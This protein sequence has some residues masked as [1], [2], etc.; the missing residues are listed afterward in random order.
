[1]AGRSASK[2]ASFSCMRRR[3]RTASGF[4]SS[5][6]AGAAASPSPGL[7]PVEPGPASSFGHL[8]EP[9]GSG[10][11]QDQPDFDALPRRPVSA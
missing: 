8:L 2:R 7:P 10:S 11:G 6:A 1:V 9:E 5:G 3:S 4:A